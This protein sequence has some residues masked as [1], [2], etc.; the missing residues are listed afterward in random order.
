M[1]K[2]YRVEIAEP[3]FPIKEKLSSSIETVYVEKIANGKVYFGQYSKDYSIM[4][5]NYEE[6]NGT[7]H[8]YFEEWEEAKNFITDKLTESIIRLEKQIAFQKEELEKIKS[9]KQLKRIK[10]G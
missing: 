5:P 1:K 6:F 8:Q 7:L 10:R 2:V 4:I 9:A 3:D